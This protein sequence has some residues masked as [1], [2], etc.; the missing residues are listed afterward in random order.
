MLLDDKFYIQ[1]INAHDIYI[2]YYYY[3]VFGNFIFGILKAF[4]ISVLFQSNIAE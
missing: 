3:C 2:Y 1:I 4:V